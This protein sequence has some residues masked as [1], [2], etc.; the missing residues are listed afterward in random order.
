[1]NTNNGNVFVYL[2]NQTRRYQLRSHIFTFVDGSNTVR[3]F[4]GGKKHKVFGW[5]GETSFRNPKDIEKIEKFLN[6]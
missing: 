4:V 5:S 3:Y 6:S 2:K 1:M